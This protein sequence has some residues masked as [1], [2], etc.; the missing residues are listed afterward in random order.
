MMLMAPTR[1][2]SRDTLVLVRN[3][4]MSEVYRARHHFGRTVAIEGAHNPTAR[5]FTVA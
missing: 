3:A 4:S 2:G 1:F 5:C